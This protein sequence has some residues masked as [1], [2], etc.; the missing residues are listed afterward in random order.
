MSSVPYLRRR[1]QHKIGKAGRESEKR[2]A[3]RLGGRQRPASGAME[4]AKGDID[5][6]DMLIEAKSTTAKSLGV[7]FEWL[8]KIAHEARG[9]GKHPA[10]TVTFTSAN[11]TQ[12][13]DGAWIMVPLSFF[14]EKLAPAD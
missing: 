12:L 3:K 11:G 10:L 4:G 9:N 14:E 5:L 6:K 2:L 8:L 13:K 7:Q 1:N